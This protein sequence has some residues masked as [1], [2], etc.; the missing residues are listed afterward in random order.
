MSC[1]FLPEREYTCE[2]HGKYMGI[3]VRAIAPGEIEETEDQILHPG[4]PECIREKQEEEKRLMEIGRQARKKIEWL[5]KMNIGKKFWESDF[6]NFNAYNDELKKHLKIAQQFAA[7]PDGK[8]VMIGENG[9]GKTH[10]AV[11]I[12]K[13][14]GGRI[15]TAFEI[16]AMIRYS[17]NSDN[18]KEWEL[19]EELSTVPLLVIDEVEKIKES[20]FKNNWM[21]HVIGKRYDEC[22]PI[23]FIA[24][25]HTQAECKQP[26][27][28][29]P[30]CLE[31]N[32]END[33]LSR[34]VE[35]GIVMR[36]SC[37]DYRYRKGSEYR[38]QKKNEV[39][40]G[41]EQ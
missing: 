14:V 26:K 20:E 35:D 36:F 28:P 29:C 1:K 41:D 19:L 22:L 24:N 34:I 18:I 25:C 5:R 32:L 23:I 31:Y 10:L 33:V 15:Y 16:G 2:T 39:K 30:K 12:L 40:D 4:C 11:S 13:L 9:N 3:P 8:L 6:S 27:K 17:Y 7:N 38:S 21:S 37:E